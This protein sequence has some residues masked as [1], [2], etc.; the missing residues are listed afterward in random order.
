MVAAAA[1]I[2]FGAA[3]TLQAGQVLRLLEETARPLARDPLH[4]SGAGILDITAA[5]ERV[6]QGRIPAADLGEP[7]EEHPAPLSRVARVA[8][9]VDWYDDPIDRYGL[10]V[11]AEERLTV[12]TSAAV[13]AHI[14]VEVGGRT[15]AAG[16]LGET[17]GVRVRGSGRVTIAVAAAAGARGSYVLQ[18]LRAG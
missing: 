3:P 14:R 7:N 6:R 9:T 11:R 18:V 10:R 12:R 4:Q 13:R 1:A 5:L 16:R 17:L 15:V 2:L 8:A